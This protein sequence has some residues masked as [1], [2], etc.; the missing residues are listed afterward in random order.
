MQDQE[1]IVPQSS[2]IRSRESSS[3]HSWSHK[4]MGSSQHGTASLA[5][6]SRAD[7]ASQRCDQTFQC[8]GSDQATC[9]RRMPRPDSA[10]YQQN[11][12]RLSVAGGDFIAGLAKTQLLSISHR[13]LP[14]PFSHLPFPHRGIQPSAEGQPEAYTPFKPQTKHG[15]N[16]LSC[17]LDLSLV[18]FASELPVPFL[19]ITKVA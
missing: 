14:F 4:L 16:R 11:W 10:C 13:G 5:L 15:R 8:R 1:G 2:Y 6:N 3:L 18:S 12:P 9:C 19:G 7:P 17:Y